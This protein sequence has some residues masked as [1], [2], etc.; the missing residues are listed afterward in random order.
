MDSALYVVSTPIGNLADITDRARDALR[1]VDV[2]YAEDTRRT[3]RLLAWLDSAAS[4]RSLHEHNETARTTEVLKRLEN[5]ESCALVS[6]AGTPVISD[7]G[8]R[9][10]RAV[11]DRG[12]DVVPVP[13]PSAVTAALAASGF[14]GDQFA[15]L[16]FPPR[17]PAARTAWI[18]LASGMPMAVVAFESPRRV[19]ELLRQLRDA[20]LG[21]RRCA[22][23]RELTKL[24]ETIRHG[25]VAEL[26]AAFGDETKGEVTLVLEGE[27]ET[28]AWEDRLAEIDRA[29]A[30]W[31]GEGM[32]TRDLQAR[33]ADEFGV[34]RNAAYD[35]ALRHMRPEES[36]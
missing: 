12:Y 1:E 4:L 24:H 21:G 7:P 27:T 36:S 20:G 14:A 19:G 10:V 11:L 28:A 15:F 31:A 34:P 13:G 17:K 26:V 25:T 5:T 23:C 3:G 32:S 6:D 8:A 2:V 30:I 22:V 9:L 29:A 16:G 35:V 33:I 18:E